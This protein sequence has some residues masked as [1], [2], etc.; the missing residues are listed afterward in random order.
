MRKKVLAF[1]QRKLVEVT[2]GCER[3]F[4]I[5]VGFI[6]VDLKA[7]EIWIGL[8][9][10]I[11][12]IFFLDVFIIMGST[13]AKKSKKRKQDLQDPPSSNQSQPQVKKSR[14]NP[15]RPSELPDMNELNII[16][17]ENSEQLCFPEFFTTTSTS[18]VWSY[19]LEDSTN[20]FSDSQNQGIESDYLLGLPSS[21]ISIEG[22]EYSLVFKDSLMYQDENVFPVTRTELTVSSYGF[23]A[24]DKTVRPLM[25][26]VV[27]LLESTE[28]V[29]KCKID[30]NLFSI[31]LP[32]RSFIDLSTSVKRKIILM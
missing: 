31:N 29:L 20:E 22:S 12:R 32:A 24:D 28:G 16:L 11:E 14:N 27:D 6:Q 18:G 1:A 13:C 17:E 21:L 25:A 5:H 15:S 8:L 30:G 10:M 4:Y 23:K 3:K 26:E 7:D 2:E 9:V 19:I